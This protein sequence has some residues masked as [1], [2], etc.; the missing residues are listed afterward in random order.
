MKLFFINTAAIF[1]G[2]LLFAASFPNPL[3]S[4][5]LPFLAWVAYIPVFWVLRNT[6]SF[7][8][9][10]TEES[11]IN[12][13]RVFGSLAVS[14]LWGALYGYTSYLLFLPW[15]KNFHPMGGLFASILHLAYMA[16]LFPLLKLA[17]ILYPRKGYILQ[18]LLWLSYEYLKTK[19]F[20]GFPYGITGYTQWHF[21]PIIGIASIFGVWGV[22]ALVLFPSVY[23]GALVPAA[24]DKS[25]AIRF[26]RR[27]RL[28]AAV[29][30]GALGGALIFG[31]LQSEY[32]EN[33]GTAK[34]ALIQQNADPWKNDAAG[35]K[36]V[37]TTLKNLSV[38]A[39]E[40]EPETE[41][42][43][44]PETAVT[45]RIF[46][47]LT[48][49]DN[50]ESYTAVKE[51]MD[52][53]AAQ[54]VPFL[55]GNDDARLEVTKS[56][57]WD[58]V[59]YNAAILMEAGEIK[60]VYRKNH[61]VPFGEYFPYEKTFPR[62]YQALTNSDTHFWKPGKDKLVFHTGSL[63]FSAPI[64]FEDCF[65]Y[66]SRDFTRNGAEFIVNLTNDSWANSLSSQV[67]HLSMS[68]FRAVENRR[69]L[70]RA[71]TSGQTCAISPSGRILAM[72]PPFTET[73]L[74]AE[75]PLL[76]SRTPYTAWGDLWAVLFCVSAFVLLLSG[77][78]RFILMVI[79]SGRMQ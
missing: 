56:G 60:E 64:C 1:S 76:N 35:A 62:I 59:D 53:L 28:A 37:L 49:R 58:R 38:N 25:P 69:S 5:G 34:I 42:V 54:N 12:V 39:L 33:A 13:K 14:S 19:G 20:L 4:Y 55:L 11:L 44:W 22:S 51:L 26:L 2:V 32:S 36:R 71:A 46:W 52:F 29:W 50:A 66:I 18:W 6:G 30:L 75:I 65:G 63:R 3:F 8:Y 61:L 41:L 70:V 15:L 24:G 31:L 78:I 74:N 16:V 45:H 79:K 21:P 77:A 68:V 17:L 23:V 10:S 73:V 47:H 9:S 7:T 43:V 27:E 48:Y 72:A 40:Q 57:R 67:Q